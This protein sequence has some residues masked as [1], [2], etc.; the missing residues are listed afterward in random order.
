[1]MLYHYSMS[2]VASQFLNMN[3]FTTPLIFN[4]F[5]IEYLLSYLNYLS[6]SIV[7]ISAATRLKSIQPKCFILSSDG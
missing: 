4:L 5:D 6:C 2:L 7:S 1:M 3:I